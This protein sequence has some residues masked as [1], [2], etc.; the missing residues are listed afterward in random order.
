MSKKRRIRIGDE[1]MLRVMVSQKDVHYP[2]GLVNGAWILS[3]FG[4]IATELAV[5]Y[6]GDGGLLR[7]YKSIDLL[8]PI[9]LGDF[10]EA[11]GK[12]IK[13]GNSS[14]TI[15]L[16]AR[17]VISLANIPEQPSAFDVLDK[18]VTVARAT[19]VTVVQ[20]NHQRYK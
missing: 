14:R 17:K 8:A 4:D 2:F 11:V 9:F 13:V 1:V 7:A 20:K 3:L 16:E 15:E 6:D 18:P 12:I 19:L 5:R 10:I